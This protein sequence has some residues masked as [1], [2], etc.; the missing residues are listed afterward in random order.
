MSGT[1][2]VSNTDPTA[3]E[4]GYSWNGMD[5][6][7]APVIVTFSFP[8]SLPAYDETIGGFTPATV[9]SFTAFTAAEQ[10][11]A[12]AA[13]G[14]WAAASGIVFIEVPPGEGDI[15]FAN[16]NFSTTTTTS[17]NG[18]YQNAGG[19]GFYPFG[20]WSFS[21]GNSSVGYGFTSD[22]SPA[23]AVFMNSAYINNGTID[24]GTLLHEIG[25]AIGMK[26]PDQTLYTADG[27]YHNHVLNP[28]E[29]SATITIMSE[30]GDTNNETNPTLFTLD[31]L[32]A[33][34]LY[35]PA[36]TGGVETVSASGVNSVSFWTWD[37]TTDT[38]TQTAISASETIHGTSVNDII[39]GYDY[40]GSVA[41]SGTISMFGLDGNNTLYAGSGNTNLYGGPDANTLIG[42][43]GNDS[44][45][46]YSDQTSVEDAYTTGNNELYAVGVNATLPV[47]VDTL[48]LY[49]TLLTGT[50]NDQNDSIFGDGVYSNTLIAGS[51]N[52]YMVGGSGGN[53]LVS[54]TGIDT[55]YGGNGTNTAN[56][57]V[58]APGSAPVNN[59]NGIDY[60]GDFRPGT[61]KL[62]FSAF[63]KAGHTLSF[64]GTAPLTAPGQVDYSTSDGFTFVEGDVTS[65]GA[66]DFEIQIAGS[67]NLQASDFSFSSA[68]FATGTFILTDRG[69]IAVEHLTAG[70]H[71]TTMSG[72]SRPVR[73]IGHRRID[74]SRHP[75]PRQVWPVRVAAGAFGET[76]PRRDLWLSPDHAVY[77]QGGL[78]PIK[79]LVNGSTIRQIRMNA[80]TYY[81]VELSGHDILLAEGLPAE[82]YL[83]TG[84][85][86]M[87][88]NGGASLLLHPYLETANDQARRVAESC[89]PLVCDAERVEP[90][91]H[92]LAARAE[93]LGFPPRVVAVTDDPMLCIRIGGR[94]FRPVHHLANRY[95]FVLARSRGDARLVS[96]SAVPSD[97]RPWIA[98]DRKLGVAIRRIIVWR[99]AECSELA[100]DDPQLGEGWWAV[101]RDDATMWRWTDGN[102]ALP[103]EGDRLMVEIV[104]GGTVPYAVTEHCP[105][106]TRAIA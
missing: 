47:N 6:A 50:G 86:F 74:C 80:V 91:W 7:G 79:L 100:L 10:A 84:N 46:V 4:S 99:G 53:T 15:T 82:S 68:C 39:Y 42:G 24:L 44:F 14:Q 41:T 64:V 19:I 77:M 34:D 54:G 78:I 88:E 56:T 27:V 11:Q 5:T 30:T 62:D 13:L 61:D 102:A 55:M 105:E 2:V 60:I 93:K 28:M 81:H 9:A 72:A 31:K 89:V 65:A 35:G 87:F 96:R 52:D 85:R 97:I 20:N 69:E 37:A 98:D 21:T 29:N 67:L 59:P 1:I 43:A 95:Q 33:A 76:L 75:D 25:H 3:I 83:D 45:Y 103:I 17:T 51:G 101:E 32:A 38:L 90:L 36:G 22:L 23:G 94:D 12:L 40:G 49:G 63:A 16:V 8:T 70:D 48:Q 26:H 92:S 104:L 71:V 106:A 66:A 18:D 73:W 57:F 58:F